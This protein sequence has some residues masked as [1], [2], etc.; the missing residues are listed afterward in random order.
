M[1]EEM[2]KES[3]TAWMLQLTDSKHHLNPVQS[4]DSSC[5]DK[6]NF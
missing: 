1:G 3:D 5:K 4:V 6:I 2:G